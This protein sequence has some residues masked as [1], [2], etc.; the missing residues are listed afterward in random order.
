MRAFARMFGFLLLAV[1]GSVITV[2]VSGHVIGPSPGRIAAAPVLSSVA[3]YAGVN[4]DHSSFR[5]LAR[6]EPGLRSILS[7]DVLLYGSSKAM[8]GLRAE[9]LNE[10]FDKRAQFYNI[11][12]A[13][14]EGFP[15]LAQIVAQNGIH[16]RIV[17]L[18]L[19]DNLSA[20]GLSKPALEAM[21]MD[22]PASATRSIVANARYQV[23]LLLSSKLPA[24]IL[25]KGGFT[26]AQRLRQYALRNLDTGDDE[27]SG[28]GAT[29]HPISMGQFDGELGQWG[30]LRDR[31][32][33]F[34]RCRNISMVAIAIPYSAAPGSPNQYS[35]AYTKR[36]ADELGFKYLPIRDDGLYTRDWIH[37]TYESSFEYTKRLADALSALGPEFEDTIIRNRE[38]QKDATQACDMPGITS[39]VRLIETQSNSYVISYH[40]NRFV[41]PHNA[42]IDWNNPDLARVQGIAKAP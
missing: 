21:D 34:L 2:F 35:P 22:V 9:L 18:D 27:T 40:S 3:D 6:F 31:V 13:Y 11:S 41:I 5:N 38:K 1:A 4:V 42:Q 29:P 30:G 39:L 14:G 25:G 7:S 20:F 36:S 23:D 8:F 32:I 28:P 10:D 15:F 17:I 37:L 26:S 19:T 12:M 33:P 24:V 16:D